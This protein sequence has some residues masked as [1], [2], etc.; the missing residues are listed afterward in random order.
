MRRRRA[1]S[2]SSLKRRRPARRGSSELEADPDV[3]SPG[4]GEPLLRFGLGTAVALALA[5]DLTAAF[6]D[7]VT[8]FLAGFFDA[9]LEALRLV[10]MT[11]LSLR[12]GPFHVTKNNPKTKSGQRFTQL[13]VGHRQ[14]FRVNPRFSGHRHEIRIAHPPWQRM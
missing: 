1:L 12:A 6:F 7:G 14:F 3:G 5:T 8:F 2:F 13:V 10:A 4:R 11:N 9:F